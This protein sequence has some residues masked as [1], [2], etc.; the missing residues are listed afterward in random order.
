MQ[1]N[2]NKSCHLLAVGFEPDDHDGD[3]AD[4]YEEEVD[5]KQ[6]AVYDETHLDPLF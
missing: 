5:A 2:N 6:Q 4:R 3:E 1:K